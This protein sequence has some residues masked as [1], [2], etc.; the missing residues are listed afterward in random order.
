MFGEFMF[1]TV[2]VTET[3]TTTDPAGLPR[4]RMPLD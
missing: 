3:G 4:Q 2:P 1:E